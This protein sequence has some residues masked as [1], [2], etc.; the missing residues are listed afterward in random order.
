M[1]NLLIFFL[2]GLSLVMIQELFKKPVHKFEGR[3]IKVSPWDGSVELLTKSNNKDTIIIV[4]PRKHEKFILGQIITAWTG[5]HCF[6]DAT[7]YPQEN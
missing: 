6:N 4:R 7:T 2:I 1:R 3:V 5:G